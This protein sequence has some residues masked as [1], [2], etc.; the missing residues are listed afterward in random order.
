MLCRVRATHT[1]Q[2]SPRVPRWLQS[3]SSKLLLLWDLSLFSSPAYILYFHSW[4]CLWAKRQEDQRGKMVNSLPVQW[5]SEFLVFFPNP[6]AIIC[7]SESSNSCCM[8]S[9]QVLRV[10]SVGQTARNVLTLS[11]LQLET[12]SLIFKI[13]LFFFLLWVFVFFFFF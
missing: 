3:C 10:H 6:P 13:T 7:F 5:Y 4:A 2:L 11:C 9:V 1:A 8:Y 12:Q